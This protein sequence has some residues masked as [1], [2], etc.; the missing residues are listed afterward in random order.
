MARKLK[1][2][3]VVGTRPEIIR[4]SRVLPRLD[5]TWDTSWR[6]AGSARALSTCASASAS[7]RASGSLSSGAQQAVTSTT[8]SRAGEV[9]TDPVLLRY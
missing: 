2:V 4:L 9:G 7:E 1:V 8:G 6:R 3:T 5:A